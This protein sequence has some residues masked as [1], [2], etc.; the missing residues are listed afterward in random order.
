MGMGMP[1]SMR[2]L[3]QTG[4]PL[5]SSIQICFALIS[6][7]LA[8]SFHIVFQIVFTGITILYAKFCWDYGS[9]VKD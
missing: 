5:S 6:G 2:W 8:K 3:Q 9:L 4:H 7:L 1:M